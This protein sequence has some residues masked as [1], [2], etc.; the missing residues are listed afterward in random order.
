[1]YAVPPSWADWETEPVTLGLPQGGHGR[2][3]VS[4]PLL[5]VGVDWHVSDLP[6]NVLMP[7]VPLPV[8]HFRTIAGM[9]LG[10]KTQVI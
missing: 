1:M 3:L 2:G 9:H 5:G 10:W 7:V 4:L 6:C 8:L